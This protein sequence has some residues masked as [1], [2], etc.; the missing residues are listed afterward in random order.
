MFLFWFFMLLILFVCSCLGGFAGF[1]AGV[2]ICVLT[3]IVCAM[4]ANAL[5]E[6]AETKHRESVRDGNELRRK[7]G[8]TS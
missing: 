7:L 3:A 8:Y 5:A 6:R 2:V 4:I 1:V